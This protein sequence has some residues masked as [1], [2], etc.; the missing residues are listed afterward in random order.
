MDVKIAA[1]P[2]FIKSS[3]QDA[4]IEDGCEIVR[5]GKNLAIVTEKNDPGHERNCKSIGKCYCFD[6]KPDQNCYQRC[7]K[8]TN[9]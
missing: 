8:S 1:A 5:V 3:L 6:G 9:R 4:E 7:V 2:D